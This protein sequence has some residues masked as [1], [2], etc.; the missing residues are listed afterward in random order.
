MNYKEHLKAE[1]LKRILEGINSASIGMAAPRGASA[2]ANGHYT[3]DAQKFKGE[4]PDEEPNMHD[5][6]PNAE[7]LLLGKKLSEAEGAATPITPPETA[8][9]LNLFKL[10]ISE[11]WGKLDTVDRTELERVVATATAGQDTVHGRLE[12]IQQQMTML[13]EGTLGKIRNPRRM[14]SQIILLETFNRLFKSFQPSP[15]G[16][17]NEGLLSVFYGSTQEDAGEANKDFQIGDV[18]AQDGSPI[19]IKT[20]IAGKAEVDGSINNL[21]RSMN[22][23]P[24]GKVYFD[25]FLKKKDGK[26][27]VGSL[28]Y[29]RFDVDATNINTFLD[30]DLFVQDP[31]DPKK[32]KVKPKYRHSFLGT[33]SVNEDVPA[34]K[35]TTLADFV[36]ELLTMASTTADSLIA[37]NPKAKNF[38]ELVDMIHVPKYFESANKLADELGITA[39][40]NN[41]GNEFTKLENLQAFLKRLLDG[42]DKPTRY[43]LD[44]PGAQQVYNHFIVSLADIHA[45]FRGKKEIKYDKE[46]NKIETDFK[47]AQGTWLNFAK[48]QSNDPPIVLEFDDESIERTIEL[49]VADIDEAITDMFN[50][51]AAF[52]GTVQTYLTTIAEN[53]AMIGEQATEQANE[54]P[55]KTEKVVEVAGADESSPEEI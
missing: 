2:S 5:D 41:K 28:T 50:G 43:T 39:T 20:K 17:I 16:F 45:S 18:I 9:M 47:L 27:N 33:G 21:Y 31:K 55:A 32:V 1:V 15:A 46:T 6:D 29:Y 26:K 8:K 35:P 11:N 40:K 14:L 12:I 44:T 38:D 22:G 24:T 13:R 7:E 51:L 34:K 23:S 52:T 30:L 49:A 48:T 36:Q 54:L 53:R 42:E 4:L 25:I 37:D 3:P 19:S 10:Q